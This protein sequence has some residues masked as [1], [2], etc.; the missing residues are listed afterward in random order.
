MED[1]LVASGKDELCELWSER[2]DARVLRN[3]LRGLVAVVRPGKGIGIVL[4]IGLVA[5]GEN[6]AV[7]ELPNG[8]EWLGLGSFGMERVVELFGGGKLG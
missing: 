4:E 5:D 8:L 2:L 3:L 7:G 1:G 6:G